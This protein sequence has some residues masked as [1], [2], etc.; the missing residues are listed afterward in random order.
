M[1]IR[2]KKDYRS[3]IGKEHLVA[4]AGVQIVR[5]PAFPAGL[6]TPPYLS[7]VAKLIREAIREGLASP[8]SGQRAEPARRMETSPDRHLSSQQI[9]A[10]LV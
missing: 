7:Q 5:V 10:A 9:P 3:Y 1:L 4:T 8:T 2:P 6:M